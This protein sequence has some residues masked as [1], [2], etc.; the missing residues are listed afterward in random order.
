MLRLISIA[1]LFAVSLGIAQGAEEERTVAGLSGTLLMPDHRSSNSDLPVVLIVAGSGPVDRNGN[2]GSLENNSL[3]FL[4]EGLA[5]AGIASVRYDKRGI[6]K[7]SSVDISEA[8]M[9]FSGNVTDGLAWV[10]LLQKDPRF[11]KIILLG[12][13][14]GALVVTLA[15][16]QREQSRTKLK[17]VI[18]LA[19]AGSPAGVLLK[20]QLLS[21]GLSGALLQEAL[22]TT[23]KLQ[24]GKR[25]D[26]I[27]KELY[28][29][30]R[31]SVQ[32]YLISWFAIDPAKEVALLK[33]PVLIVSGGQDLQIE[34]AE[35]DKLADA[36]SNG[37]VVKIA[38]MN[39]I[40]KPS[41]Q[42]RMQN[43]A[44]Y[45][46]ADLQLVPELIPALAAFIA[47]QK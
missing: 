7:S 19:G 10:D 33:S 45:S 17:G 9:L 2:I 22:E 12:H 23:D 11:S 14:E 30:F 37:Q 24:S 41:V 43:F 16:Q 20:S 27:S 38:A 18:L 1:V 25:V 31:P 39:H 34:A 40:L 6:G 42:E 29:L 26:E 47:D 8:N 44:T 46:R 5:N 15:A 3:K 28:G 13:S 35:A 4:A 21:A 32:N 36:A